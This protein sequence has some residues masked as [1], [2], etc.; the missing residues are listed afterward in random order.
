[1]DL[2]DSRPNDPLWIEFNRRYD[3]FVSEFGARPLLNQTKQLSADIV[4]KT[5]GNDWSEFLSYHKENDPSGRFLS[6]Y[7]VDLM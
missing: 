6:K 7:F 4:Y 5:L 3:A 2:A 1:M